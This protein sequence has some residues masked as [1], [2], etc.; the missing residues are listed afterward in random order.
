MP[1][2]H[3]TALTA[4]TS[5]TKVKDKAHKLTYDLSSFSQIRKEYDMLTWAL[6]FLI[7]AIIAGA[8]GMSGVAGTASSIA[9]ILFVVGLIVAL[10]F[11]ISGRKPRV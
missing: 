8:L 1:N 4:S 10:I 5:I 6:I 9:W 11:F 2:A 7:I 3:D